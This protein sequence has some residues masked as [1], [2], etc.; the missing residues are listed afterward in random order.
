MTAQAHPEAIAGAGRGRGLVAARRIGQAAV[1]VTLLAVI[2][3]AL[4]GPAYRAGIAPLMVAFAVMRWAAIVTG[5]AGLL[6]LAGLWPAVVEGRRVHVPESARPLMRIVA[7]R[8][9]T[10]LSKGAGR[11]SRAV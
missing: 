11:H 9:D 6:S 5:I 10:H 2:V 7:A 4:T 3:L 1:I 8:F